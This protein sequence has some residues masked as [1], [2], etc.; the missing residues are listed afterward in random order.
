MAGNIY[1]IENDGKLRAMVEQPYANEELL[2]KLLEDYP[3]LLAGDAVDTPTPRRLLLIS[4]EIG[5][6]DEEDGYDRWSLD[7]LFVDKEGV[8]TLVEVKRSSDTRIRREVV[9]QMLDYAANAIV[10]W[11]IEMIRSK[12]EI[13][14]DKQGKNSIQVI[15]EFLGGD[16]SDDASQEAF[17]NLVKTNLQAGK[18]R[19][20]F[21][22]DKIPTELQRIVEFLNRQMD[23]AEVIAIELRQYVAEGFKTLVPRVLGQ[24]AVPPP[25]TGERRHWDEASFFAN[26]REKQGLG[27][28]QLAAVQKLYEFSKKHADELTW[29][30][31]K[32]RGSFNPKFQHISNKSL[33]SVYSDGTLSLNFGWLD[34]EKASEYR[35]T[36][37]REFP[38]IT[39]LTISNGGPY[40]VVPISQWT[41]AVD[42]VIQAF[43]QVIDS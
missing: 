37:S 35:E 31:G 21:L 38:R 41:N 23:P 20:V 25:P 19:L 18:V 16:P 1:L 33:Y 10:Y 28:Q 24:T 29:G 39:G 3:D 36:L 17:W 9:G 11:P 4:R 5:V 32:T 34:D 13:T 42:K 15:A 7:H 12:F 22:A 43:N 26:A 2:Q 14:C 30:T 6:P 8:P 27:E 40:P